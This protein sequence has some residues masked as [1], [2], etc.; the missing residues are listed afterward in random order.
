VFDTQILERRDKEAYHHTATQPHW[1]PRSENWEQQRRTRPSLIYTGHELK[2]SIHLNKCGRSLYQ[3]VSPVMLYWHFLTLIRL[4]AFSTLL[5]KNYEPIPKLWNLV[6]VLG[7]RMD[8]Y[9]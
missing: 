2:N 4:A 7:P 5:E 3:H 1:A 9:H 8:I 6:K